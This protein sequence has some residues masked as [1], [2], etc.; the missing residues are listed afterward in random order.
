MLTR[1]W[2]EWL[3][4]RR[5]G[6]SLICD[7]FY[8]EKADGRLKG[9]GAEAQII[10]PEIY[11]STDQNKFVAVIAEKDEAGNPYQPTFYKSRIHID[12]SDADTYGRNF[13]QL[14]RWAYDKPLHVKPDLGKAPAFLEEA[15]GPSL[16]TSVVAQRAVSAI[17]NQKDYADGAVIE[18]FDR[19]TE[20]L[21]EFR[22]APD[23]QTG[24]D[25]EIVENIDQFLPYRNEAIEI[26]LTLSRYAGKKNLG[27]TLHSFV[28]RLLPYFYRPTNDVGWQEFHA[29]NYEFIIHE[30]FLYFIAALLKYGHFDAAAHLFDHRYYVANRDRND[31][32]VSY[33]EIRQYIEA[34]EHRKNRLKLNRLSLRADTLIDRCQGVGINQAQL[35]QS[36]FVVFI[37]A[38][39]DAGDDHYRHWWP[40]TL[41]YTFR[42]RGPFELFARAERAEAFRKLQPLLGLAGL[43]IDDAKKR[44]ADYFDL[45]R[46]GQVQL[47]RWEVNGFNPAELMNFAKLATA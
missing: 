33:R 21:E 45:I 38:A 12:L 35:L 17:R 42:Q 26:V 27:P 37:R 8:A 2:S 47:P 32:M 16:H 9:V 29:S 7:R 30:L 41:L 46:Q 39:L 23:S 36:D 40:E 15:P 24:Y 43:S 5:L 34:F 22:I 10:S 6:R 31:Q 4:I 14:L 3:P 25:D 28:E 20:N 1:S 19:F 18:Y 44:I 13:E 11:A